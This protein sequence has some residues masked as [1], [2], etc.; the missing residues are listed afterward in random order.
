MEINASLTAYSLGSC[1]SRFTSGC[2]AHPPPLA[3]IFLRKVCQYIKLT[4][5]DLTYGP[6]TRVGTPDKLVLKHFIFTFGLDWKPEK[7]SYHQ[8]FSLIII[9]NLIR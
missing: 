2:T 5:G 8:S 9:T 6:P 3:L 7:F 4:L 1:S